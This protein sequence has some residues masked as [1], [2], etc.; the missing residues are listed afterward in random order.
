V[1]GQSLTIRNLGLSIDHE[2]IRAARARLQ[3][4]GV[5]EWA[6]R[7]GFR[8]KSVL[9]VLSGTRPCTRGKSH[10]IAIALGL[11]DVAAK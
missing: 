1:T 4:E 8:P 5:S 10:A 11:K 3:N 9:D 6:R 7:H 2:R